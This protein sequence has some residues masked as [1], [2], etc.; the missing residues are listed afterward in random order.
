[1]TLLI[2]V[3]IQNAAAFT[4]RIKG[5]IW[6]TGAG[7]LEVGVAG[8]TGGCAGM[9]EEAEVTRTAGVDGRAGDARMADGAEVDG[10]AKVAGAGGWNGMSGTGR[11][12]R[13]MASED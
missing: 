7:A 13:S 10:D 6:G 1:M 12:A 4:N 3:S 11:E 5:G 8:M 2:Q 9:A